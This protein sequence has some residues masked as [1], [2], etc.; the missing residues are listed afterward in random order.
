MAFAAYDIVVNG[1]SYVESVD[2]QS[3][4]LMGHGR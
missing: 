1:I 3:Y 2:D 4:P